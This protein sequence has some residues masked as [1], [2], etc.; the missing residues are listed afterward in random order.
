MAFSNWVGLIP[1]IPRRLH[2][3]DYYY[4]NRE[5]MDHELGRPKKVWSHVF[6]VDEVDGEPD[7]RSF[8]ILSDKL[9]AHLQEYVERDDFRDYDFLL[10]EFGQGFYKDW[11]V[12]VIR[13]PGTES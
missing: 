9:W 5:I 6:W 1:G 3:T 2:F 13:R 12:Q 4:V 11:N 8:S 7:S 10:T